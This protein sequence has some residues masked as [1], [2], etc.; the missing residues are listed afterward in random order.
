MGPPY[1]LSTKIRLDKAL[2]GL[3]RT[4]FAALVL[5]VIKP[6]IEPNSLASN[7]YLIC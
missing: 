1:R 7:F 5:I 4:D 2:F 6:L 3:I